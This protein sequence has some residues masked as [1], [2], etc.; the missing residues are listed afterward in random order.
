MNYSILVNKQNKLNKN[1]I[2]PSLTKVENNYVN[3]EIYLN[4][5]AYN[6]FLKLQNYAKN[7]GYTIIIDSGYRS[8]NDQKKI[9][10]K[11]LLQNGLEKTKLKVA[12]PG[13]SEHQT[14]LSVDL[15]YIENNIYYEE[16]KENTSLFTFLKENSYKFGFILRYPKNKENIT[17]YNFEPWHYR[18]VGKLLAKHLYENNLTL[19]EYKITAQ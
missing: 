4:K 14:G 13:T 9:W 5:T 1:Y 10:D 6:N 8:Y 15:G 19:E 2:P 12:L 17:G 7:K 18:Y 3:Y 16:I 11:F